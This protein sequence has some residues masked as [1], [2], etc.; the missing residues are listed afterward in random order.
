MRIGLIPESSADRVALMKQTFPVPILESSCTMMLARAVMAGVRLGVFAALSQEPMPL[1]ELAAKT[2]CSAEGI[3]AL[4][5][6]LVGC[7]YLARRGEKYAATLLA[8]RWLLPDSPQSVADFV[9]CN[10]DHWSLWSN[11]EDIVRGGKS[12]DTHEVEDDPE[13]WHRRVG[14]MKVLGM[15]NAGPLTAGLSLSGDATALL[16]IGGGPGF[17]SVTLCRAYPNLRATILDTER[18]ATVGREIV[19]EAGLEDRIAYR[20]ADARYDDLGGNYDIVLLFN[21]VHDFDQHT[22]RRLCERVWAALEPGGLLIIGDLFK[23]AAP[24]P[25]EQY[26]LLLGLQ[27]FLS[28]GVNAYS[29]ELA[30]EW[31]TA[32]G[33]SGLR[34]VRLAAGAQ[35]IAGRKRSTAGRGGER[36]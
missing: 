33:F 22:N 26:E 36:R 6:A 16:D 12:L 34:T 17:N 20:V 10:Y 3:G 13:Q 30:Q 29:L 35:M 4:C 9:E 28:R 1:P 2:G 11:L 14:W 27:F 23:I 32:A 7:G 8:K 31:M 21:V 19:R 24:S 5:D 25:K 15:L 18:A